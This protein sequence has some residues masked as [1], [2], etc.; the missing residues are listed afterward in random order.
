MGE[1]WTNSLYK[2]SVQNQMNT[3]TLKASEDILPYITAE[4][5]NDSQYS[6]KYFQTIKVTVHD[7]FKHEG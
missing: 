5:H 2:V 3:T 7:H 4:C 6:K 1:C